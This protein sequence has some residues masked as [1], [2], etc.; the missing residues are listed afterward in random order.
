MD[1]LEKLN[2]PLEYMQ[3]NLESNI[4]FKEVVTLAS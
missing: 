1:L 3:N 2:G 4:H